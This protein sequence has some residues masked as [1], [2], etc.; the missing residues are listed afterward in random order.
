MAPTNGSNWRR[1]HLLRLTARRTPPGPPQPPDE[2]GTCP[3]CKSHPRDVEVLKE[4]IGIVGQ[5]D[6]L[7]A[8][9]PSEVPA[10]MDT[11]N[12]R[13]NLA[14]KA[15]RLLVQVHEHHISQRQ[16]DSLM[17]DFRDE[18]RSSRDGI[19]T[20]AGTYHRE[21]DRRREDARTEAAQSLAKASHELATSM[22]HATWFLAGA[23]IALVLATFG[24]IGATL[25]A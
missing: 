8:D 5:L 23:T 16:Y 7:W 22:K 9:P 20:A 24:L 18:V 6:D 10:L 1:A 12:K 14:K 4:I 25:A 17:A 3:V 2:V 15:Q 11:Y 19:A 21:K 13:V